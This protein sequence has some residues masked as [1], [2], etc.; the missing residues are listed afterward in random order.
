[1]W[2][3]YFES[4]IGTIYVVLDEV[5][6]TKVEMFGDKWKGY[7]E[8]NKEQL[9]HN[10]EKCKEVINQFK[11]YFSG[12]R[13][14]FTVPISINGTKFRTSVWEELLKIPYGETRSYSDI[15][16]AVGNPKGVRAIGGANKA[17]PLSIIVPCHR[18]I[19]K[20]G[21]LVGYA[22]NHTDIKDYLIELE[23]NNKG[24][25]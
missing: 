19:G 1:M 16:I 11:E 14:N 17:N 23:R 21:K 9:I 20:S 6:V 4:A 13:R 3:D 7:Y 15:A 5:G 22:G 8:F 12:D 2:Y 25:K 10:E 18:V 24:G